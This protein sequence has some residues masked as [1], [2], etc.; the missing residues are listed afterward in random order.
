M[1]D[2]PLSKY[3]EFLPTGSKGLAELEKSLYGINSAANETANGTPNAV[4]FAVAERPG[5]A[6]CILFG[7]FLPPAALAMI[8]KD[9]FRA[10]AQSS[11]G[12]VWACLLVFLT[13]MSL[14]AF[15]S[16]RCS[17]TALVF[18]EE[19]LEIRRGL[20]WRKRRRIVPRKKVAY[21]QLFHFTA[22]CG[23]GI[24][25]RES[26]CHGV[27]LITDAP[28]SFRICANDAMGPAV[29]K[30][31]L[32]ALAKIASEWAEAPCFDDAFNPLWAPAGYNKRV[33]FLSGHFQG[34]N[35]IAQPSIAAWPP[36]GAAGPGT[37]RHPDHLVC[38][39]P[40]R[41]RAS[42][43]F[44]FLCLFTAAAAVA[45]SLMSPFEGRMALAGEPDAILAGMALFFGLLSGFLLN[46][47]RR[48]TWIAL[49]AGALRVTRNYGAKR[50]WAC[51]Y[52]DIA[53]IDTICSDETAWRK[54][55]DAVPW[56]LDLR[57]SNGE[58]ETLLTPEHDIRR[59][60]WLENF[61]ERSIPPVFP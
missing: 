1:T 26:L 2:S 5:E 45:S 54:Q 22:A 10:G 47:A 32:S 58:I 4:R 59:A 9:F 50:E 14:L 44:F 51:G 46:Y 24:A 57:R 19:T 39:R 60:K 48:R 30:A 3:M 15:L 55:S 52:R 31:A 40:R 25:K 13:L 21:L 35:I 16:F 23:K 33:F 28:A 41:Y 17:R 56:R 42:L 49:E 27:R 53:S 43:L 11:A 38:V 18:R 7:A 36:H 6:G 37:R 12:A 20:L 61:L 8:G 34:E 29:D